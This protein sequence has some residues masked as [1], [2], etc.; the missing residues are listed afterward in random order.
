MQTHHQKKVIAI[1]EAHRLMIK[2]TIAMLN[3]LIE[4][5]TQGSDVYNIDTY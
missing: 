4:E 3:M 2:T 5:T 1:M